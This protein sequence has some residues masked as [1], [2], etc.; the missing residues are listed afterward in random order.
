MNTFGS[1]LRDLGYEE[2]VAKRF[3]HI[4]LPFKLKEHQV[5]GLHHALHKPRLGLFY[6]PRTG[7][8]IVMQLTA[9]LNAYYGMGTLQLMP[10]G[11]FRQFLGDY[12]KISNHGLNIAIFNQAPARRDKAIKEWKEGKGKPHIILLS[13]EIFKKHK[14]SLVN[15]GYTSVHYDEAHMGLQGGVGNRYSKG[16]ETARAIKWFAGT[17]PTND[18][19]LILSTGSPIP[20]NIERVYTTLSLLTPGA[21]RSQ[22]A[23]ESMHCNYTLAFVPGKD[24]PRRIPVIDSYKSL[25]TLNRVLYHNAVR[26]PQRE[27]L[28]IEAPNIQL[29]ETELSGPHKTLYSKLVKEMTLELPDGTVLD[30]RQPQ[31]RR[32]VAL[33]IVTNPQK[34]SASVKKNSVIDTLVALTD[35]VDIRQNKAVIFANYN[36]S[37]ETIAKH[38]KSLNPAIVYGPNGPSKNSME[39]DR[40]RGSSCNL[41][42]ANPVAGGVGFTLGDVCQ[43]IIFAEPVGSPGV[44]EQALSRILLIGQTE[45]VV[46]YILKVVNTISVTAIE[47]MLNKSFDLDKVI[48]DEKGLLDALLGKESVLADNR[49]M[50]EQEETSYESVGDDREAA[51][52]C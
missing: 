28:N 16:S 40:F 22:E 45:P 29:I 46:C 43:T 24:G 33:Q 35:S 51:A 8:T 34:Y 3:D 1:V 38:Y 31:K 50:T 11:L 17:Q 15:L 30:A 42:V 49:F 39:V 12:G 41:L 47:N 44:F 7:K 10:P 52:V 21:Y 25:D 19:R 48:R 6:P 4:L 26:V 23:F 32:E 5:T 36:S 9:I 37:V 13:K 14:E 20:T 27:V 18:R 2:E